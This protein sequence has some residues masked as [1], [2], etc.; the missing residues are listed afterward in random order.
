MT[1]SSGTIDVFVGATLVYS[2]NTSVMATASGAGLYN[3][4]SGLGLVNRWDNFTVF[5]AP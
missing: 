4:S 2:T 3:N 5:D 1:R